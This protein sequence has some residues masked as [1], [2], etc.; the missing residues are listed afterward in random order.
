MILRSHSVEF[1]AGPGNSAALVLSWVLLFIWERVIETRILR[2]SRCTICHFY[3]VLPMPS[4]GTRAAMV[5]MLECVGVGVG[6]DTG[7]AACRGAGAYLCRI[8]VG[9][10]LGTGGVFRKACYLEVCLTAA[11]AATIGSATMGRGAV[12]WSGGGVHV[13]DALTATMLRIS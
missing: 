13:G 10:L 11:A 4:V 1:F 3:P 7:A 2:R 8:A 5:V 12:V 6:S 9:C